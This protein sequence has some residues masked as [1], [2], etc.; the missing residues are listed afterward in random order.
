MTFFIAQMTED[1]GL[2]T[3]S[4]LFFAGTGL[5]ANLTAVVALVNAT[6]KWDTSICKAKEVVF[7]ILGPFG[8]ESGALSLVGSKIANRIFLADFTLE[9]DIGPGVTM[10]LL[11]QF[12]LALRSHMIRGLS[13]PTMAMRKIAKPLLRNSFSKLA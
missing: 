8:D 10:I 6:I 1:L 9:V 4:A 7:G 2:F 13:D 11:L 5:V 12:K 3:G